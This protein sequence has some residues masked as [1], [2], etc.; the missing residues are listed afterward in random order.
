[1][2]DARWFLTSV[3]HVPKS[4]W[5]LIHLL[6]GLQHP[7]LSRAFSQIFRGSLYV[8][9]SSLLIFNSCRQ[10]TRAMTLC[11]R[12]NKPPAWLCLSD[13]WTSTG[14][15]GSRKGLASGW[16]E[17]NSSTM[18]ARIVSIFL[19]PRTWRHNTSYWLEGTTSVFCI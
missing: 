18:S 13:I 3:E 2:L 14:G 11:C 7:I 10:S 1:M 12:R 5:C 17:N 16:P 6:V 8:Y 4:V 9:R 19:I 15:T